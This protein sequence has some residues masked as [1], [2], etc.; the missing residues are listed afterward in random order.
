MTLVRFMTN[1]AIVCNH[2]LQTPEFF[3]KFKRKQRS[4]SSRNVRAKKKNY[5]RPERRRSRAARPI[6]TPWAA[7]RLMTTTP[8]L[9][10]KSVGQQC[11]AR[12]SC[13]DVAAID[14]FT[15]CESYPDPVSDFTLFLCAYQGDR[16]GDLGVIVDSMSI[17]I[18]L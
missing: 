11:T 4:T 8:S 6:A 10:Q 5:P 16:A 18:C 3:E 13:S 17:K 9:E 12:C 7:T 1:P 15:K 2:G 14:F